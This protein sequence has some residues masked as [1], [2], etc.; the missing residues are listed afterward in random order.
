[1]DVSHAKRG[2]MLVAVFHNL[3]ASSNVIRFALH[4]RRWF[5]AQG[6]YEIMERMEEIFR[7]R[8]RTMP[9]FWTTDERVSL[10]AL[11]GP[12]DF[13]IRMGDDGWSELHKFSAVSTGLFDVRLR[14]TDSGQRLMQLP[15]RSD[16]VFGSGEFPLI[17]AESSIFEEN[18]KLTAELTDLS[19]GTNVIWLTLAGRKVFSDPLDAELLRPGTSPG[20]P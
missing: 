4:G 19:N 9:Y 5:F 18:M 2:A 12:T 13:Q 8:P 7:S 16:L 17:L 14:E 11:A 3:S 20:R 10:S 15:L 1:M 6:E